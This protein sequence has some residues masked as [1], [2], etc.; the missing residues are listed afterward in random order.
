MNPTTFANV[1]RRSINRESYFLTSHACFC[2]SAF[3][4]NLISLISRVTPGLYKTR[5]YAHT[6]FVPRGRPS[7]PSNYCHYLPSSTR[8]ADL[9]SRKYFSATEYRFREEQA[10]AIVRVTTYHNR[11]LYRSVIWFQPRE[12]VAIRPSIATSFRRTTDTGLGSLDKLPLELLHDVLLR[13]DMHSIFK[14]RQTNL[15]SRQIVDS[16]HEYQMVISHC[17]NLFCALLRT[18]LATGVSLSEFYDVLCTKACAFCRGFGGFISLLFW[19]RCCFPCLERVPALQMESLTSARRRFHLTESDSDDLMS[20]KTLPG[21]YSKKGSVHKSRIIVVSAFQALLRSGPQ[22]HIEMQARLANLVR[23]EI[24]NFMGSCALPYYNRRT[25]RVEHG[26]SCAGC[27]L[28][29]EKGIIS[30][31]LFESY[32]RIYGQDSFLEHFRFCEQAQFLWESSDEGNKQP[33]EL[34]RFAQ[35]VNC[36]WDRERQECGNCWPM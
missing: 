9:M 18:R 33:T 16:V 36:L 19:V 10:D 32:D 27:L 30:S 15:R 22:P 17:L 29:C 26:M 4:A 7:I 34:P 31:R 20:F 12:H 25:G 11:P 13:L 23:N 21:T 28:A 2:P 3:A 24:F 35:L 8:R 6:K 1:S 5:A 14:F